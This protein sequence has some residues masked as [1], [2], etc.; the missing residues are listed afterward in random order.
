MWFTKILFL[1][2]MLP[3]LLGSFD[4]FPVSGEEQ[5]PQIEVRFIGNSGAELAELSSGRAGEGLILFY[6]REG[7]EVD[8]RRP[9]LV[10]KLE[11]PM[12]STAAYAKVFAADIDLGYVPLVNS[13]GVVSVAEQA[14]TAIDIVA[15]DGWWVRNGITNYNLDVTVYGQIYTMWGGDGWS[16][17]LRPEEP[18]AQIVVRD[19]DN[20]GMPDW[21]WRTMLPE[22]PNRGD[23]RTN[24]VE[25]KC[26]WV[27]PID[28]GV[29]PEWPFV[30]SEGGFEQET[31][32]FRPPIV[33][34][35]QDGQ[36]RTF[37]EMVTARHHKCS[38]TIYSLQRV[39]PGQ[40]NRPDFETPFTF[41]DL[42]EEGVSHPNLILRT[43]RILEDVSPSLGREL[44]AQGIRYSWRNRIGDGQI[45]YKVDVFGRYHY[46]DETPIAGGMA[47]VDAPSFEEY[48]RWV[49]DRTWA[50]AS[51][52]AV[53]QI[54]YGSS[55][56]IYEWSIGGV[57]NA[58]LFGTATEPLLDR[59]EDI[60]TGLRGE[61][62]LQSNHKPGTYFSPIDN[63]LHLKWAEVG[64]WRLDDE[65]IIRMTNL[66]MNGTIDVWS[67]EAMK[68]TVG[69]LDI[70]LEGIAEEDGGFL[71]SKVLETLYGFNGYLLHVDD[72]TLTLVES[73]YQPSLFETLPPTDHDT[74]EIHRALLAPYEDQ[75]RD[76]TDL[77]SWLDAFPGPRSE[78]TGASV[79]NVRITDDGF[80]FE[81]ALEPGMQIAGADLLG[82]GD[83][84][85][86]QYVV[87]NRDGV[88][89]VA[90]MAPAQLTIDVQPPAVNGATQITVGNS[91]TAD[92]TDLELIVEVMAGD[93]VVVELSREPVDAR[94]GEMARQL[95]TIPSNMRA[96]YYLSARLEDSV[97]ETVVVSR[98]LS[99]AGPAA[100]HT[101]EFTLSRIPVLI[102][103]LGSFSVL[104]ALAA[105]LAVMRRGRQFDI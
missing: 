21:D 100:E 50:V 68:A 13:G 103:V 81:L 86:G 104:L 37:S 73:G 34:D 67:R 16:Q 7:G 94:A 4:Q 57:G 18:N 63:R 3:F 61:Y 33:V 1:A 102:P 30:A 76:P 42:S 40:L 99:L 90:P 84:P 6:P 78:I 56:G 95:V 83:L 24:Y 82:L 52:V 51:F 43:G 12:G 2:S 75:R 48:P 31:G 11:K 97:G 45:D 46:D 14:V 92:A 19:V 91:G 47:I 26:T 101:G 53:E 29:F 72:K 65:Q 5:I 85:A 77:R 88:F 9:K 10:V 20:D 62:R 49:I 96:G 22:F 59:F 41:Y 60:R 35:W 71:E 36:V 39:L 69:A 80:R 32:I 79:A 66:D 70:P 89:H 93:K 17:L 27:G 64:I 8:E 87:E 54:S 38:Y 15:P 23:L 25:R 98:P 44:E 28:P 74:W 58:Y 105:L 55:E